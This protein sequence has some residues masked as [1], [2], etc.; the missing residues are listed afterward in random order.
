LSKI[1]SANDALHQAHISH[2]HIVTF[3]QKRDQERTAGQIELTTANS[4]RYNS[5]IFPESR[6]IKLTFN[7]SYYT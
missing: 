4:T 3:V 6:I 7:T 1:C 5:N 2:S